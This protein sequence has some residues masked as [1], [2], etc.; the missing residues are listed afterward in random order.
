MA[1]L[2]TKFEEKRQPAYGR[3]DLRL[4]DRDLLQ[5]GLQVSFADEAPRTD[6]IR[7]DVDHEGILVGLCWT[8]QTDSFAT[9]LKS[10]HLTGL[11]H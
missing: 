11:I 1:R 5:R 4:L 7:N 8:V 6:D 3:F 9:R 2:A 10:P